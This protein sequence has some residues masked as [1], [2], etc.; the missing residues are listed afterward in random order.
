MIPSLV[1]RLF[2]THRSRRAAKRRIDQRR[3]SKVLCELLECRTLMAANLIASLDM[4]NHILRVEGTANA[5]TVLVRNNA[6]S[7]SVQGLSIRLINGSS[8]SH[9][10]NVPRSDVLR[11]DVHAL[12][13][14]DRVSMSEFNL[15]AGQATPLFVYAGAG[16]DWMMG[17]SHNDRLLGQAG[18]DTASGAKGNDNLDGG[19]GNDT[20]TG[21]LG[22]DR[23]FGATGDDHLT[24]GDGDDTVMGGDGHDYLYGSAGNDLLVGA[25]LNSPVETG[26]DVIYGGLGNDTIRGGYGNDTLVG[27]DGIDYIR[28][29]DGDDLIIGAYY[30]NEVET[31]ADSLFGD[32]GND[33][34]YGGYGDDG[35]YGGEGN[36]TLV[37]ESGSDYLYGENGDDLLIGAYWGS[38]AEAS[39]DYL[40]GGYGNDSLYGGDGN[41]TMAGQD[42]NDFLY[43]E[44]GDDLLMGAYWSS[45][46][47]TG[48]DTI[49][50]GY[51]NDTAYGGHG[52]DYLMGEDGHDTLYGEDGDDILVGRYWNA[53]EGGKDKIYGGNGNDRMWGGDGHD[54]LAG[55]AGD[56][57]LYAEGGNDTAVGGQ[58]ADDVYGGDG[59]D[60]LVGI[61]GE[62]S[63]ELFGQAG[64]DAFWRDAN[65]PWFITYY[66]ATDA[67]AGDTVQSVFGFANGADRTLDGDGIADPT[68]GTNY[69]NFRNN[70]LFADW[71]PNQNDIDQQDLGDCWLMAPMASIAQDNPTHIRHMVADF[72]DG[73]YGVRL[74]DSFYRVD[75]DLPTWNAWSTDQ[76][77][78][79]LGMQNSLWVA[80]VEKAYTHFRTGA[81]TYASLASGWPEDAMRAYNLTSV[82]GEYFEDT[83]SDTS[84]ANEVFTHYYHEQ[85][86]TICVWNP[87]TGSA[88]VGSHCYS[89]FFVGRDTSGNVT[90][91]ILRNPWGGDD[92]GGNPFV[93]L[94]P[95]ELGACD[96]L[97]SWGNA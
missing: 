39:A 64:N 14:D 84:L 5:D 26:N 88:L 6:G 42:G 23:L 43:G 51:G 8:V 25:L 3:Q 93:V 11:V 75:A 32:N 69:K 80:I 52:N 73:T 70:P 7:L 96:I 44:N 17:G 78:A 59:D 53:E 85:N 77:F 10:S 31:G 81:N 22:N 16:N 21:G 57:T 67:G 19:I 34:I 76:R 90:S 50:G 28:G 48:D 95:A 27:E 9:V 60:T 91:I 37:G 92:T 72:G 65:R 83:T 79:G 56:D 41:D 4:S 29:E 55:Q 15:T 2:S 1:Q 33:V 24:G 49:Y 68:D 30:G 86:T 71:G 82:D 40:F 54:V 46:V 89:V 47:E 20:M 12:A 87:P 58:G 66:D 97:V 74:G 13:G 38:A 63:D 18:D 62:T 61:D 36:D 35:I 45:P 94:T